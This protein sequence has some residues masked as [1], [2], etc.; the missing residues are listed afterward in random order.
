MED[1]IKKATNANATKVK[2]KCFKYIFNSIFISLISEQRSFF[3]NPW[4]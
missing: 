1:F 4:K 3:Y 2:L